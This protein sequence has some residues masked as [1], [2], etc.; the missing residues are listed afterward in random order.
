MTTRLLVFGD[1]FVAGV[2]D[3]HCRGWAGRAA[4]KVSARGTPLI[5]FPLG[6]PG[7]TGPEIAA[8]WRSEAE[9]RRHP[10]APMRLVFSFGANDCAT[11]QGGGPRVSMAETLRTAEDLLT[12]AKAWAPTLMIGPL[13]ICDDVAADAR[14]GDLCPALADVCG[15]LSVPYLPVFDAMRQELA[16]TDGAAR[17]DGTHPDGTGYNALAALIDG[18]PVWR[19]TIG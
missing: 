14:I 18:W 15:R 13:P 5:F 10:D 3:L 6:I 12:E 4:A 11:G 8:R 1:S 7:Q 16:W 19:E 2:G 9:A 17:N